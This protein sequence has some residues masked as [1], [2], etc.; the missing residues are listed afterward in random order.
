MSSALRATVADRSFV[1]AVLLSFAGAGVVLAMV[2]VFGVVAYT[3]ARRRRE[4]GIRVALGA[5]RSRVRSDVRG[6]ALRAVGAGSL[7]GVVV[8]L[9]GAGLIEALLYEVPARDPVLLVGVLAT[10]LATAYGASEIPTWRATR[11]DPAVI[12]RD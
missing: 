8:T 4:I 10:F 11:V 12:L 6:R 2:G 1:V 7:V 5:S 3:V 9:L